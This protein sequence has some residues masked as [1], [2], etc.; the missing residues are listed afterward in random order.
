VAILIYLHAVF[1]YKMTDKKLSRYQRVRQ[2]ISEL[3]AG[4]DSVYSRMATV[5]AVLHNKMD[6]FFWTGFYLLQNGRLL[7]G[8]YQGPL[9]CLE[10]PSDKGV[11]WASINSGRSIVV[12]DVQLFPGHIACDS[13]SK[14]EIVIPVRDKKGNLIAVLDIDSNR[15]SNFDDTD[16]QELEKISALI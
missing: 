9:A 13:R 5:N 11:C 10:L 15:L 14:S 4:C 3:I 16:R 6:G 1:Q 7:V 2:Q 8:P 12:P